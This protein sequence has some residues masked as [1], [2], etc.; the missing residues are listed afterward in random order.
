MGKKR[1][2]ER[3]RGAEKAIKQGK[4][5]EV[6]RDTSLEKRGTNEPIIL[7]DDLLGVVGISGDPEEV[8]P[9]TKLVKTIVLLLVEEL[10]EFRKRE[11]KNQLKADFL[12]EL[13][14]QR[15]AT[16]KK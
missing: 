14:Y 7:N 12:K 3:H 5:V 16:A 10:N 9:F 15:I 2:G 1:I 4:M 8:R 13:F 6:F 11:K